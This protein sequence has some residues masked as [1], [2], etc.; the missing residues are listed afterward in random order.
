M[1]SIGTLKF[2]NHSHHIEMDLLSFI[3]D[4]VVDAIVPPPQ[5]ICFELELVK[6]ALE[7]RKIVKRCSPSKLSNVIWWKWATGIEIAWVLWTLHCG[8]MLQER[9]RRSC[10]I[11]AIRNVKIPE[12]GWD[13][14]SWLRKLNFLCNGGVH[15]RCSWMEGHAADCLDLAG[16]VG[17][18]CIMA[19]AAHRRLGLC[20]WCLRLLCFL[21]WTSSWTWWRWRLLLS[22]SKVWRA[23]FLF[24]K[25]EFETSPVWLF[26]SNA[27]EGLSVC[28]CSVER[29]T[30]YVS[31]LR[32]ASNHQH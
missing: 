29:S 14:I 1:C 3:H 21:T 16:G 6:V 13:S 32:L 4:L 18:P 22:P 7:G 30:D 15:G 11:G 31:R 23:G 2:N 24:G 19:V 5:S 20:C 8:D 9:R 26:H 17:L 27:K 10:S 28:C 12:I 25:C